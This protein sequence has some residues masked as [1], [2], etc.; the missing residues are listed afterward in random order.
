MDACRAEASGD[1]G[2]DRLIA[3]FER[4]IVRYVAGDPVTVADADGRLLVV[5]KGR[6]DRPLLAA[7]PH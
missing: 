3:I 1:A 7:E 4:T 6:P 5:Q 2:L